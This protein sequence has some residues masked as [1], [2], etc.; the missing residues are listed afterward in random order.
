MPKKC[1]DN[2]LFISSN[3]EK[4]RNLSIKDIVEDRLRK[5]YINLKVV[6]DKCLSIEIRKNLVDS[7]LIY[8]ETC[9]E[10]DKHYA[11][12]DDNYISPDY[13]TIADIV[14]VLKVRIVH[15]MELCKDKLPDVLLLDFIDYD[16]DLYRFIQGI[17]YDKE[18]FILKHQHPFYNND[19]IS[20][21]DDKYKITKKVF[22]DT[23][24]IK[25]V[26][27]CNDYSVIFTA[28]LTVREG[29]QERQDGCINLNVLYN[30]NVWMQPNMEKVEEMRK[31]IEQHPEFPFLY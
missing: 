24:D 12:K 15:C 30:L 4:L 27:N 26:Q 7:D 10:R 31:F 5:F 23:E 16:R 21:L 20:S 11:H 1:V 22:N 17:N 6:Y 25:K 14:D 2:I 29:I 28:G 13:S 19:N 18:Q 9:K 3:L 8:S